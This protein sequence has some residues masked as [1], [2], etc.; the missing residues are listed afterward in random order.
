MGIKPLRFTSL[1]VARK[2]LTRPY[3]LGFLFFCLKIGMADA[4]KAAAIE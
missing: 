2:G 1:S 4:A 3:P